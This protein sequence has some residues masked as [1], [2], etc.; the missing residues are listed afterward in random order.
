MRRIPAFLLLLPTVSFAQVSNYVG[1]NPTNAS[2]A[3]TFV[4]APTITPD[5]VS[6]V[7]QEDLSNGASTLASAVTSKVKDAEIVRPDDIARIDDCASQV[8][9]VRL[10]S[11][12]T[13]PARMGQHRGFL[14]VELLYFESPKSKSPTATRAFEASGDVHWGDTTPFENAVKAVAGS[15]RHKL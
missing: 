12:H 5:V 6:G 11:Y 10:K 9:V 13:E 2:C 15:M 14:S 8:I 4:V 7:D 3:S 1:K